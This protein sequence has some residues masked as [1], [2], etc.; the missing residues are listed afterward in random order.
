MRG[1]TT[2]YHHIAWT[3][4]GKRIGA[5]TGG[6]WES[7]RG[8]IDRTGAHRSDTALTGFLRHG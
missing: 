2:T 3:S 5:H 1:R 6:S 4:R 8:L 7:D